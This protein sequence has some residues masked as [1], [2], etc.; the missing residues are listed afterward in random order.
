MTDDCYIA[1]LRILNYRF[2]SEGE[3]RRKLTAKRFDRKA[4]DE[5]IVRLRDEKWLD[6]ERFA[7]AL[8]RT[9][10]SK[11]VGPRKIERELQA[12]GIDRETAS[13]IVRDNN[14]E[15]REREDLQALYDKRKRML[16]RRHGEGYPATAEGRNKIAAYLLKQGYDAALVRRVVKETLLADD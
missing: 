1:A 2:N 14:N 16:I 15:D 3:L 9:R 12:A 8:V 11:K 4:I 6:D 10:M 13:R 7:G 5:T